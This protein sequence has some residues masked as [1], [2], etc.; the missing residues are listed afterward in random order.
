MK[1]CG[2]GA[3]YGVIWVIYVDPLIRVLKSY[4]I[5][6][7]SCT[8][9]WNNRKTFIWLCGAVAGWLESPDC[10]VEST[11][12][13]LAWD[14]FCVGVLTKHQCSVIWSCLNSELWKQGYIRIQLYCFV[15]K[16]NY[17]VLSLNYSCNGCVSNTVVLFCLSNTS[18]SYCISYI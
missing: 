8:E 5:N 17:I 15:S 6:V 13:S 3:E 9:F 7:W 1:I 11:G 18:A 16:Y 14:S 12:L 2:Y 10:N 4:P